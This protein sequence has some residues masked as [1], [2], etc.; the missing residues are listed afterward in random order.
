MRNN[1]LFNK[2][3]FFITFLFL[4]S[5]LINQYYGNKGI[6]P[7]D[8]F[9]HFDT[10]F[11]IL[12]GEYPFKDYWVVSGPL[13]DYLQAIFFYFFGV[14]WQSYVFHA[15][16]INAILTL[17]TFFVLRNF[18]LNIYYSFVYSLFFSVL[19]YPT[20]G[21]PFVDHHS[22]FFSLLGIYS[23]ILGIKTEKK[24]YW[25]LLPVFFVFGFLSKQVPSSY[26]ILSAILVL[27]VFSLVKQRY[28]WLKYSLFSFIFLVLLLLIF[29]KFQGISLSSF[30]NQYFFY[31]QSIGGKRIE[32]FIFTFRGVIGHFKF[33]YI[34]LIPLFF[35]NLKKIFFETEY[36]KHK[37]FYYFLTLV[38]FTFA[39]IVHQIL[40]RNQTFIFFL[41]PI[42]FAFSHIYLSLY[43]SNL[44]NFI[45]VIL[46]LICLFAVFKYHIRFNENRKFHEFTYTNFELASDGR[47]IDKKF[48]G[49][50]WITSDYKNRS[51]EEIDSINEVKLH[52][53]N[54]T[55]TKMLITN[56]SFFSSILNEKLFSPSRWHI[57][58]GSDYP[59]KNN[60]YF[61]NYK[62]LLLN[63]IKKNNIA[64]I[65]MIYPQESSLIYDYIDRNCFAEI[66]ISNMLNSY[67]LRSCVEV[68]G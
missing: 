60:K 40:T 18:N 9:A 59:S 68:N 62:N 16:L 10:G 15:S 66:K 8:S 6:F 67:E 12:L 31:P 58:D 52:L 20:S 4:F 55:R 35:I 65:Y 54:D 56:Y 57:S 26:I 41:I 32:N 64:V 61:F 63:L 50:K 29:G 39:L 47:E 1:I 11:R 21:T 23:L 44:N 45:S 51:N 30:L 17:S 38:L 24:I 22:A 28:N 43:K 48:V 49:L 13:V 3:N 2:K 7:A 27:C 33:I 42:L 25:I 19:A 36:L 14:N 5:L 34:A 53:L 46:I 37:S